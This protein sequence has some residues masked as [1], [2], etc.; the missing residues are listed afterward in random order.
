MEF[1]SFCEV[2]KIPFRLSYFENII[3]MNII[4]ALFTF[5][6]FCY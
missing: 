1:L 2:S 5:V 3:G 4:D 6:K